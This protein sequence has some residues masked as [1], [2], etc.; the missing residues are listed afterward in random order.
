MLAISSTPFQER[1]QG[2]SSLST[3]LQGTYMLQRD[4]TERRR[5]F[6]RFEL[7]LSLSSRSRTSMTVSPN[8]WKAPT[9]AVWQNCHLQV[10]WG[11][12]WC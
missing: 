4:W 2:P 12:L 11:S 9:S 10:T 5:L 7:S 3:S 8:S 6:T 1:G